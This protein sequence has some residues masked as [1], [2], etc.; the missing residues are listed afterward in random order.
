MIANV[1]SPQSHPMSKL[2]QNVRFRSSCFRPSRKRTNSFQLD[3]IQSSNRRT[4]VTYCKAIRK[5]KAG[6]TLFEFLII[7]AAFL[8]IIYILITKTMLSHVII[9]SRRLG[10]N[11]EKLICMHVFLYFFS[12]FFVILTFFFLRLCLD[13]NSRIN[14]F[15]NSKFVHSFIYSIAHFN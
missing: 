10:T 13:F 3:T 6:E 12:Y 15:L 4:T 7:I 11:D 2:W 14:P 1:G 9:Y 5:Q 8:H